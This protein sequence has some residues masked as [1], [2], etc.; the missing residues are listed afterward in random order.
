MKKIF[1]LIAVLVLVVCTATSLY[2]QKKKGAGKIHA[3]QIKGDEH[4]SSYEYYLAAQEYK[5][6]VDVEPTN[7]YCV[8]RLAESYREYFD[9]ASAEKYYKIIIAKDL[10]QYPLARFWYAITLRD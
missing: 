6:V 4:F 1:S 5:L 3:S 8:F 9:Y 10:E 2:A 7:Y